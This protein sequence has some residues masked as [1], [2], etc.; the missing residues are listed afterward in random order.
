MAPAPTFIHPSPKLHIFVNWLLHQASHPTLVIVCS[1]KHTFIEQLEASSAASA[2]S[3]VSASGGT[4]QEDAEAAAQHGSDEDGYRGYGPHPLL[5]PTLLNISKSRNVKLAF[6]S[7]MPALMAYLTV[8]PHKQ[9]G[10]GPARGTLV[11]LGTL[12][13][14]KESGSCSAQGLGRTVAL[15][16]Q[17]AWKL[18]KKLVLVECIDER[19]QSA[20]D[21]GVTIGESSALDENATGLARDVE[22][23]EDNGPLRPGEDGTDPDR[24]IERELIEPWSARLPVVTPGTR[25]YGVTDRTWSS[26]EVRAGDVVARWCVRD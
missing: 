17:T 7:S 19:Q 3:D 20:G 24:G 10:N 22:M 12:A 26:K 23:T 9:V 15:V 8:L 13:L 16:I 18:G 1:D 14:H 6:V 5:T 25:A 4:G 21:R 2:R 11:L